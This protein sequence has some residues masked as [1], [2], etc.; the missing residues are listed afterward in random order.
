MFRITGVVRDYA[1]GDPHGIPEIL[2]LEPD[3]TPCAEYW[4]GAHPG[5][6]A[7]LDEPR[8]GANNLAEALNSSPELLGEESVA[9]FGQRLPFLLKLLSA[10]TA[11]S[12][13][14]HPTREQAIEG[15]AHEELHGPPLGAPNRNYQDE[16][17]KPELVYPLTEFDA[18]CG[19]RQPA[20][21]VATFQRFAPHLS[22]AQRA[23]LD[24][25]IT[26]LQN[27]GEAGLKDVVRTVLTD[28]AYADLADTL[29]EIDVAEVP[30][31]DRS[32]AGSAVD[33]VQTLRRV[34]ADFP[35][36]AGAIVALMLNM[37][38]LQPGQALA[39]EAGILHAYL[40][41]LAVEIMASSDNVL[42]GGLTPKHIDVDELA[43]VVIY[44]SET[45]EPVEPSVDGTVRGTTQ[46]FALR[47]VENAS[48][49][50]LHHTGAAIALCVD[51]DFALTL[52]DSTLRL[53]RG[54]ALFIPA[55]AQP[56]VTG[57]GKLFIASAGLA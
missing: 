41:G 22:D 39:L 10:R 46:D 11:L 25:L 38:R 23:L 14:A 33:P 52:E 24:T 50:H 55:G 16:W 19:F 53:Q 17:H 18:L 7:Q 4:L 27:N 31:T 9:A 48:S 3:G 40:G 42:R 30:P 8:N 20:A 21:I 36:D 49:E 32:H 43:K 34:H 54:Q 29:A 44:R 15:F 45:P 1:W 51:G 37:L 5:A 12:I 57:E 2:G 28:P 35:H 6:P 13:Q 56:E 26:A 47:H